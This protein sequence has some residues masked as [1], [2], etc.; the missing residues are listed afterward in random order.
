VHGGMVHESMGVWVYGCMGVW[1]YEGEYDVWLYIE[2]APA[3]L[4]LL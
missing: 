4:R 1:A 2:S 3:Y